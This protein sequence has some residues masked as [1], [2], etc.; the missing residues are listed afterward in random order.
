MIDLNDSDLSLLDV[1]LFFDKMPKI[2]K[3][4]LNA[5]H[6]DFRLIKMIAKSECFKILEVNG[7]KKLEL[8]V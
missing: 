2:Y 5:K 7:T 4:Y 8:M 1:N 6:T 3:L